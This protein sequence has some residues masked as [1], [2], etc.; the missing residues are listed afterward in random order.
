MTISPSDDSDETVVADA[1]VIERGA[2]RRRTTLPV[3]SKQT[4]AS[5][6]IIFL[7]CLIIV[8]SA[9][10]YGT[11][12]TWA[13]ALFHMGAMLC[14]LLWL[15]DA[16]T[17]GK[18][19]WSNS[20][21][22]LPLLGA[23]ILGCIQLLPLSGDYSIPALSF[24]PLKTLSLDPYATRFA[25]VW[26]VALCFYFSAALVFINDARRMRVVARTIIIFG[27]FLAIFG[28]VQK[29]ISPTKIYWIREPSQAVPFGPFINSHHFAAYME[30]ALAL[31][32]GLL[33]S[34]A[35]E[36]ERRP[37]YVFAALV[38]GVALIMTGSRGAMVS[39][40]AEIIFLLLISA[41]AS[42]V[43][44]E[45]ET[46][47]KS[48]LRVAATRLGLAFLLVSALFLGA[49]FFG[50]EGSLNRLLG[51]VSAED[52]TMGRTHFWRTTVEIVRA[53][54]LI[55][56]GLGAY[57][58]AYT[59][60]DTW[61]GS[62]RVE[63]AHNDYLQVLACTGLAGAALGLWFVITLFRRGIKQCRTRDPLRRGIATGALAGCFAVLVHSF[64][65]FPLQTTA[66]S[67]LFLI[68]AT[69]VTIES[70][71]SYLTTTIR[72]RNLGTNLGQ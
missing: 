9:L 19:R 62:Y 24:A 63:Q 41:R 1:K 2:R 22:Q 25:L 54:P 21:L 30:M 43:K 17:T 10:A 3:E 60:Y 31:P 35:V 18:L 47:R 29:F 27:F 45:D 42:D 59:R 8:L 14:A 36:R 49:L 65:D 48:F 71:T 28:M 32:L 58:V 39:L 61:N 67:L 70:K 12:H 72:P 52:P 37:L 56:V 6:L 53:Y 44:R 66:N 57:G 7:L 34:G 46:D 68:L 23:I 33:F 11:V 51:T 20:S 38:M 13:F 4:L 55:G 15:L 16:W 5:R 69:L 26:L 40:A 64:F 50:G